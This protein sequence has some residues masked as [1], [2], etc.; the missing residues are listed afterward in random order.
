MVIDNIN[1]AP[2]VGGFAIDLNRIMDEINSTDKPHD[3]ISEDV[4]QQLSAMAEE[5]ARTDPETAS[6]KYNLIV[7]LLRKGSSGQPE[8]KAKQ[9][10]DQSANDKTEEQENQEENE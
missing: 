9:K 1:A 3:P 4:K 8:Q 7:E 10:E 5:L 6:D 2:K